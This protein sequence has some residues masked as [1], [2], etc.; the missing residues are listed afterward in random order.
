ITYVCVPPDIVM[1]HLEDITSR[2]KA[3]ESEAQMNDLIRKAAFEWRT[4]FDEIRFPLLVIDRNP[5]AKWCDV[6]G[7]CSL[8]LPPK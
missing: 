8:G 2:K 5:S 6:S 7:L 4:T 1:A 3:E